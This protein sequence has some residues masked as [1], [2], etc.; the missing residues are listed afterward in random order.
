MY[1][2][3]IFDLDKTLTRS[4]SLITD[5]EYCALV[6]L[7]EKYNIGIISGAELSQMLKQIPKLMEGNFY[8]MSQSGNIVIDSNGK[9]LWNFKMSDEEQSV[10]MKHIDLLKKV[11]S[12]Q[13][14]TTEDDTIENRGSQITFSAVGHHAPQEEKEKFDPDGETRK[15]W[16]E[17]L[18]LKNDLVE[19]RVAGTTSIDYTPKNRNKGDNI[20]RLMHLMGWN[21]DECLFV[22]DAL[23]ESG[24]DETMINICDTKE[25]SNP[26]ETLQI[27]NALING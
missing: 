19:A 18:P 7:S 16:L 14:Q 5:E 27:I 21:S 20:K 17:K 3:I 11:F 10:A 8:K 15:I 25:I 6:K 23:F 1:K 2:A 24:N 12:I 13:P 9:E 22:G 4:R 26:E